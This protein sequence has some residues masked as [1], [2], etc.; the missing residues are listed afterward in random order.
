[1]RSIEDSTKSGSEE[2]SELIPGVARIG[3]PVVVTSYITIFLP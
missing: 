1:M 3:L 2:A